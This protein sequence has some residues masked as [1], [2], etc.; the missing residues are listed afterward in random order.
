MKYLASLACICL[1][2]LVSPQIQ[3]AQEVPP[4][5][6]RVY[7]PPSRTDS[8]SCNGCTTEVTT[9]FRDGTTEMSIKCDDD[10]E[11]KGPV[12]GYQGSGGTVCGEDIGG[13]GTG[14]E[15]KHQ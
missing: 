4:D 6:T 13:G 11:W 14:R 1:V 7:I 9:D 2:L 3:Y 8:A 10:S 12:P 15:D 5:N